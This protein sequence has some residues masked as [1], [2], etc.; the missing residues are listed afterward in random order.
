[1]SGYPGP[2]QVAELRNSIVLL[3]TLEKSIS[4][5]TQEIS[6]IKKQ[7]EDE[8]LEHRKL[9]DS[10]VKSLYAMDVAANGNYGWEHRITH[11]LALLVAP[12]DETKST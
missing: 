7:V 4:L 12:P 9:K 10:I 3:H 1:M 2:K 8:T 5:G 6:K 11:F